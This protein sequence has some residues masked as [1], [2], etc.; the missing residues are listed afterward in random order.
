MQKYKLTTAVNFGYIRIKWIGISSMASWDIDNDVLTV[1]LT[2][3]EDDNRWD[4]SQERLK[5]ER[6]QKYGKTVVRGKHIVCIYPDGT[7]IIVRNS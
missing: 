1:F 7:E 5:E 2:T 6:E 4:E 3:P